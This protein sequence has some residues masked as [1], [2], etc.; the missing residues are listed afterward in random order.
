MSKAKN[1][2][3]RAMTFMVLLHLSVLN[4]VMFYIMV[5]FLYFTCFV[6]L[7]TLFHRVVNVGKAWVTKSTMCA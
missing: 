6:F 1:R 2:W 7:I 4:F 3:E 5:K